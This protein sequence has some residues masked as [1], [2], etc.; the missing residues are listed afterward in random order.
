MY[1]RLNAFRT[2]PCVQDKRALTRTDSSGM[3][4]TLV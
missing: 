3:N 2:I 4:S 1:T